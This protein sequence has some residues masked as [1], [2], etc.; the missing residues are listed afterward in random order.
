MTQKGW[1]LF[2]PNIWVWFVVFFGEVIL[3]EIKFEITI[4]ETKEVSKMSFSRFEISV[5]EINDFSSA[6]QFHQQN[7]VQLQFKTSNN[8]KKLSNQ[9][10]N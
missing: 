9:N 4:F 10:Q 2:V 1:E 5:F 7:H 6:I 8:G 3:F